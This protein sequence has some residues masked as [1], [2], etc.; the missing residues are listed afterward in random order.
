MQN[1]IVVLLANHP[2]RT[3]GR[4]ASG[5]SIATSLAVG[6]SGKILVAEIPLVHAIR[7]AELHNAEA[8]NWYD[9]AS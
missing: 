9:D 3:A 4:A 5:T 8:A 2:I 7:A 1:L 6:C